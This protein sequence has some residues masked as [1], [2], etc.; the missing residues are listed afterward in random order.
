MKKGITMAVS[1]LLTVSMS[2]PAFAAGWQKNDTGWWY[3]TNDALTTW[4]ANEWQ[5]IDGNNDGIAESYCFDGNGYLY[6]NTTTP[7]GYTVN[8]DGAWTVN[9]AVQTQAAAQTQTQAPAVTAPENTA[10]TQEAVPN[11][12]GTYQGNY[13]GSPA[14]ALIEEYDGVYYV[15]I[16]FLLKDVLPPYVGNG[17]FEDQWNRYVFSGDSLIYTELTTGQTLAFV[18][19]P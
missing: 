18:K 6:T 1:A 4:Y 14:T 12:T 9:G 11:V 2:I 13:N 8:S 3:A 5:W 7:D 15:E 17:V 19:M 10:P 16:D